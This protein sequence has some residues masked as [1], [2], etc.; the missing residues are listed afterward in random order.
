VSQRQG[1]A[2]PNT[3][4]ARGL[5][6][7]FFGPD[8]VGKS[9]VID[10]LQQ[11]LGAAFTGFLRF[12]FRPRFGKGDLD[13]AA[14]TCPHAQSPRGTLIS[15]CKLLYWLLDCWIGHFA[16]CITARR[17]RG[18]VVFDRYLP[19]IL[20]D[21]LRYRLPAG[22]MRLAMRLTKLAPQPDLYVLLDASAETVQTRKQEISPTESQR[23]RFAYLAMFA[24]LPNGLVINADRPR[25]EV[26]QQ[27]TTAI[28][29][30]RI[31]GPGKQ[32]AL[33]RAGFRSS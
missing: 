31:A 6:I 20:V 19:D 26:V 9:A 18:L 21:P 8:G 3:S 2:S 10:A 30:F 4:H 5:W 14:V 22:A 29:S 33:L 15:I 23:Q 1:S 28:C 7:A 25:E 12:H 27:V 24:A 13:R 32:K 11:R 17:R 16:V